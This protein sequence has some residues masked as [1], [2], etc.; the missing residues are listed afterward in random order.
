MTTDVSQP[1]WPKNRQL[2]RARAGTRTS[3]NLATLIAVGIVVVVAFQGLFFQTVTAWVTGR[4]LIIFDLLPFNLYPSDLIFVPLMVLVIVV[5]SLRRFDTLL[6]VLGHLAPLLLLLVVSAFVLLAGGNLDLLEFG[7]G[8]HLTDL[9]VIP[10]LLLCLLFYRALAD[11]RFFPVQGRLALLVAWWV[12][13][14]VFA[15]SGLLYDNPNLTGDLR[16][17]VLRSVIGLGFYFVGTHIDLN[18]FA[19]YVIRIGVLLSPILTVAAIMDF[20]GFGGRLP[21]SGG[22]YGAL[23]F[24]LAYSLA[25]TRV[26]SVPSAG[27]GSWF[28][29]VMLAIACL[30]TLS[31]PA[32]GGFALSTIVAIIVTGK[33]SLRNAS[34]S[35]R[36]VLI[37]GLAIALI[38]VALSTL[39]GA[40]QAEQFVRTTYLKQDLAVED[41]SGNRFSIWLLGVQTWLEQPVMGHGLGYQMAGYFYN[42][43]SGALE[44]NP[45][46][47]PHNIAVQMLFQTGIVGIALLAA[48]V[49]GWVRQVWYSAQR[50]GGRSWVHRAMLVLVITIVLMS[51][52]GQFIGQVISGTL[53]WIALGLEAALAAKPLTH[54]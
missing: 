53:L 10:L 29:V 9:L 3:S 46:V 45:A 47:W 33:L 30:A 8:F 31:K 6:G 2:P 15:S 37:L 44:Y 19:T 40:D 22:I 27:R 35:I 36:I 43:H 17:L 32:L 52:Y 49:M 11:M 21:V 24:F 51:L 34:T 48:I 54:G 42:L 12:F 4:Q 28:S 20:A 18:R 16:E 14:M 39:G 41:L 13:I 5:S 25:I 1:A 7:T 38:Y 23:P 26:L 50:L